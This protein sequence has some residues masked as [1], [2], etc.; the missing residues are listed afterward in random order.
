MHL[1]KF[2]FKPF[3]LKFEMHKQEAEK[4]KI[5]PVQVSL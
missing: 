4:G 5:V 1:K 3:R 2:F